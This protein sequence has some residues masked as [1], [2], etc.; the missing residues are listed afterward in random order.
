MSTYLSRKFIIEGDLIHYNNI[1]IKKIACSHHKNSDIDSLEEIFN[2]LSLNKENNPDI[3][4]KFSNK[5]KE[6]TEDFVIS[7]SF[8][9]LELLKL[10]EEDRKI[11]LLKSGNINYTDDMEVINLVDNM[12]KDFNNIIYNYID[13]NLKDIEYDHQEMIELA[14]YHKKRRNKELIGYVNDLFIEKYS[15]IRDYPIFCK[16]F[17]NLNEEIGNISYNYFLSKINYKEDL[18]RK[19]I[20]NYKTN[21]Y[22]KALIKKIK[23]EQCGSIKK[24]SNHN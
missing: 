5:L 7:N 10:T 8:I 20:F 1:L 23:K 3:Y 17:L 14:E 4:N 15:F 21:A 2:I 22:Q 16:L 18:K 12:I 6:F 11:I 13:E 19:E 9:I 24:L